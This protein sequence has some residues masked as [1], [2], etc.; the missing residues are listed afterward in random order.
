MDV[1]PTED[2]AL[3]RH[4]CS[5]LGY[6]T[7][8]PSEPMD[9]DGLNRPGVNRARPVPAP[10]AKQPPKATPAYVCS[11]QSVSSVPAPDGPYGPAGAPFDGHRLWS[12]AMRCLSLGWNRGTSVF[13]HR[14]ILTP[15]TVG[16]DACTPS[17]T[18]PRRMPPALRTSPPPPRSGAARQ[19]Y[20]PPT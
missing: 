2:E 6:P 16:Q 15:R 11:S 10:A 19:G 18:P 20:G 1:R 3:C 9:Q 12:A 17:Q 8:I 7:G 13:E 4:I 5:R 14:Y